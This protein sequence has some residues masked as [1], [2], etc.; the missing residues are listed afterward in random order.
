MKFP[1]CVQFIHFFSLYQEDDATYEYFPYFGNTYVVVAASLNG[2]NCLAAFVKMIQEWVV[3]L[4]LSI[5]QEKIWEKTIKL[6]MASQLPVTS[7]NGSDNKEMKIKPTLFGERHE[8]DLKGSILG[9]APNNLALGQVVRALCHGLAQNLA[10]MMSPEMLVSSG[11]TKIIGSGACLCRNPVLM[12]EVQNVYN[13]PVEF[14]SEGSAC[15]GAALSI[16]DVKFNK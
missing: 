14:T 2:G 7:T 8:P 12:E 15:I 3:D 9:L 4:G 13:L 6:G 16:I 5:N 11:M 1:H 10:K